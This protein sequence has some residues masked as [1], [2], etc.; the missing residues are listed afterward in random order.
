MASELT[1][2]RTIGQW[3]ALYGCVLLMICGQAAQNVSAPL[4]AGRL[5]RGP[6]D[7]PDAFVMFL[8]MI[9]WYPVLFAFAS[10]V[11]ELV[12]Q[13][14]L[15]SFLSR[16]KLADHRIILLTGL[17]D[18]L[19]GALVIP[20]SP[21]ERTPAV[22]AA[23]IMSTTLL[24]TI[25]LKHFYFGVQTTRHYC[26]TKF[27][28]IVVVY[29]CAAY[30]VVY[31]PVEREKQ[32]GE[33]VHWWLIFFVGSILGQFYNVQQ[34]LSFK[35]W[36]L[37]TMSDFMAYLF[38][39]TFYLMLWGWGPLIWMDVVPNFGDA[40]EHGLQCSLSSTITSS[41]KEP[42]IAYNVL[43]NMGYFVTYITACYV[44]KVDALIGTVAGV[45]ST[46]L[47]VVI[48]YGNSELTPDK[49]VVNIGLVPLTLILAA[50]ALI[51]YSQW[52]TKSGVYDVDSRVEYKSLN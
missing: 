45:I 43:F 33:Q 2:E 48:S 13:R 22:V 6:D 8:I 7:C 14:P 32:L 23:L 40:A 34:E 49:S 5:A 3:L 1:E 28:T 11:G 29:S 36:G 50:T 20:A 42:A 25:V 41:F 35:Q 30:T 51:L 39:Q 10:L 31:T 21:T 27:A 47:V 52:S 44:N 37:D 17:C 12:E 4:W 9:L 18:A 46:A 16:F 24:P 15:F 38:W 19:N 26:T